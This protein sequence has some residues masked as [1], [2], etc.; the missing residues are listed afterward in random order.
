MTYKTKIIREEI[1]SDLPRS[2]EMA[3]LTRLATPPMKNPTTAI[4]R[5]FMVRV[6]LKSESVTTFIFIS[7]YI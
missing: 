3:A 4:S 7:L 5:P 6:L 1:S 2:A